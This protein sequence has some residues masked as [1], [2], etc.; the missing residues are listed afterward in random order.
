MRL[1]CATTDRRAGA[2]QNALAHSEA[3]VRA[4]TAG[5]RRLEDELVGAR[6]RT[7]RLERGLSAARARFARREARLLASIAGGLAGGPAEPG[8]ALVSAE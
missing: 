5:L 3:A 1:T 6:A 4:G 7:P 8:G 2:L